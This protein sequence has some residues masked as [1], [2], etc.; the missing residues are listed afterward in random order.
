MATACTSAIRPA[1]SAAGRARR[2]SFI[3]LA[4][5]VS[6]PA[7]RVASV[8]VSA[9]RNAGRRILRSTSS[10]S[11]TATSSAKALTITT[12]RSPRTRP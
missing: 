11:T 12:I 1:P 4:S 2:A 10:E 5:R 8:A 7:I 9:E 3:R 6:T